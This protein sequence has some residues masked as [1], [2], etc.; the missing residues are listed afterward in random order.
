MRRVLWTVALLAWAVVAHADGRIAE[1]AWLEGAWTANALGG[2][3]DEAWLPAAGGSMHGVCRVTAGDS[4]IFSE[5]LQ[6]TEEDGELILRF[7]H[8]RPDYT[9]W[10]G[11]GPPMQLRVTESA[12]GR[13]VFTGD[14][15]LGDGVIAYTL[16]DGELRV[17][18]DGVD[19]EFR[20]RRR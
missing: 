17:T 6:V 11:D 4:L 19:E 18:V 3:V 2:V 5:F 16:V 1:L 14:G 8:F 10:E 9:T 20:F 13:V 12:P 7:E 15:T